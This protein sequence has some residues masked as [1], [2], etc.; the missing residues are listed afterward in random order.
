MFIIA[1]CANQFVPEATAMF[2][3]TGLDL[4]GGLATD[5]F[6]GFD[7]GNVFICL[8]HRLIG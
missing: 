8:L 2:S 7:L 3:V 5:G 6:F 1:F 4:K